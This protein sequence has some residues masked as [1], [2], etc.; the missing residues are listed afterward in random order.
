MS[1]QV[2]ITKEATGGGLQAYQLNLWIIKNTQ[3]EW[4]LDVSIKK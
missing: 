4:Y 3:R 1:Q 2:V